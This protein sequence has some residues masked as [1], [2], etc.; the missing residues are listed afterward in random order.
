VIALLAVAGLVVGAALPWGIAR[1]PDREPVDGERAPTPYRELSSVS[2]LPVVLG[3]A[4][5]ATWVVMGLA[6]SELSAALPAFLLVG[7]LGVA[8]TYV[9][10]REHR[11]PDWLTFP[12]FGGAALALGIA[13]SLEGDWAS[14]GRAWAGA[15]VSVAFYLLLVLLR[16]SDL[17]L[18]DVKLAAVIGLLLGWIGWPVLVFGIFSAF[19]VG[20]L[21]GLLLIVAGRAGRRSAIPFGPPMLLGMVLAVVWG[22][23]IIDAYLAL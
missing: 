1:I 3:V 18:G 21:L 23:S 22:Q 2:G 12:A 11:L 16:P 17:G 9:D 20:A 15:G 7:A 13:A 5:A 6:R 14:Y 8:M 4:A 10:I 19:V